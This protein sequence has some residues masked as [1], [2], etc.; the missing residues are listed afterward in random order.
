MRRATPGRP[1][2]LR[3]I[4]APDVDLCVDDKHLASPSFCQK[5][6]ASFGLAGRQAQARQEKLAVLGVAPRQIARDEQRGNA[7]Q[8]G[9]DRARFV[10]PAHI[11][12][13][14]GEKAV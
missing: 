14:R 1:R 3:R 8:P 6:I 4:R 9:D 2:P 12:I 10:E 7:A 5:L 13:A 11:G